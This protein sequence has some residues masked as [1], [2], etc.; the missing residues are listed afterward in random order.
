MC[1]VLRRYPFYIS[2][3]LIILTNYISLYFTNCGVFDDKI[4]RGRTKW[5]IEKFL[6]ECL[7]NLINWSIIYYVATSK[8]HTKENSGTI[9]LPPR[10]N[11][12]E[13]YYTQEGIMGTQAVGYRICAIALDKC[14]KEIL[15]NS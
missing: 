3:K 7:G 13:C 9:C 8:Y 11:K 14:R 5:E 10:I 4:R 12:V 2:Q 6:D 1:V 15:T